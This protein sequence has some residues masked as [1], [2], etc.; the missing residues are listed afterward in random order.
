M[1]GQIDAMVP[2]Y[3]VHEVFLKLSDK[4]QKE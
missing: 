4:T 2:D 3:L 1:P